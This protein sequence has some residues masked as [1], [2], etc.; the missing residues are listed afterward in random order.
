[1]KIE[2]EHAISHGK[3]GA[4]NGQ[5]QLAS[6]KRIRFCHVVEFASAKADRIAKITSFYVDDAS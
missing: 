4:A 1:M 6:G 2:V 5:V 3:S